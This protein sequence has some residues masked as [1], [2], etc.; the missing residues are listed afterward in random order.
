MNN[1]CGEVRFMVVLLR[2]CFASGLK[3]ANSENTSVRCPSPGIFSCAKGPSRRSSHFSTI[4]RSLFA[5]LF[6]ICIFIP[7]QLHLTFAK[8]TVFTLHA[9]SSTYFM[10]HPSFTTEQAAAGWRT[11]A[12]E[13]LTYWVPEVDIKGT[14]P[15]D[16]VGTFFRNGMPS[17]PCSL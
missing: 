3:M 17:R 6:C 16:L 12:R 13:Q 4:P 9:L 14:L 10:A 15:K 1:W 5:L 7:L 11:Q 2:A 8:S